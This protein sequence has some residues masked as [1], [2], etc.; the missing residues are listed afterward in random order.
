MNQ[1]MT[2]F[3]L[4][5]KYDLVEYDGVPMCVKCEYKK[6]KYDTKQ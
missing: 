3:R 2:C 5:E 1:C 6:I 4:C